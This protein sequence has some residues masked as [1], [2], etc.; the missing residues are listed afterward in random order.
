MKREFY[1]GEYII[2]FYD[3]TDDELLHM[4]DNVRQ[5]LHFQKKEVTRQNVNQINVELC[6]ALKG[7]THFTKFLTG[8]VMTVHIIKVNRKEMESW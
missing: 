8:K 2:C 7:D 6:R 3:K 1:K 4:F 5:I